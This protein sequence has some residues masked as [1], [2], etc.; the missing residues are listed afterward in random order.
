MRTPIHYADFMKICSDANCRPV[1]AF[2]YPRGAITSQYVQTLDN[3]LD[4]RTYICHYS[5][6]SRSTRLP[7][8]DANAK[9]NLFRD[10]LAQPSLTTAV[11]QE[12]RV[13]QGTPLNQVQII[14]A[15]CAHCD[16]RIVIDGV[17]RL[18]RLAQESRFSEKVLITEISGLWDPETPDFNVVCAH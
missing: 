5:D 6:E 16:C 8:N 14:T 3:V 7:Y 4:G 2:V 17:H 1:P 12:S 15:H 10:W 13:H 18:T 9:K 11:E